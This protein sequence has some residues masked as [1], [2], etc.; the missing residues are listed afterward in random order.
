MARQVRI[1]LKLAI[2]RFE[3]TVL[4][5][6]VCMKLAKAIGL[7]VA[8]VEICHIEDMQG[9]SVMHGRFILSFRPRW[10]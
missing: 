1:F 9:L 7:S 3:D 8:D 10:P 6:A 2:E 5:E 4:N